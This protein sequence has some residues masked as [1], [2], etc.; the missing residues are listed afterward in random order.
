MSTAIREREAGL[1][2][3]FAGLGDKLRDLESAVG[4]QEERFHAI[5]EIGRALGSTLD[6]DEL[7]AL[8]MEKV[9]ALMEADRSTLFLIDEDTGEIWSKIAQG[10]RVKEIRL[11]LGKGIAG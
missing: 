3:V 9:T 1:D 8:V 10:S 5:M 11:P 4:R 7:L 2:G 6:L